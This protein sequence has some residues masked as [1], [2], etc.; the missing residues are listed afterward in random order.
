[1]ATIAAEAAGVVYLFIEGSY[2]EGDTMPLATVTHAWVKMD[3]LPDVDL[4]P[5]LTGTEA[6][7]VTSRLQRALDT[8][9][10]DRWRGSNE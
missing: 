4:W 10:E 2:D 6:Q 3:G 8:E 7:V 9:Q 1:M 5:Y